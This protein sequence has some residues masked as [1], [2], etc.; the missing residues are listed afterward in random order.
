MTNIKRCFLTV[1]RL[2]QQLIKCINTLGYVVYKQINGGKIIEREAESHQMTYNFKPHVYH[3]KIY[4]YLDKKSNNYLL[5]CMIYREICL[6]LHALGKF[7]IEIDKMSDYRL[8]ND[9]MI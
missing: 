8:E 5:P 4:I 1:K 7:E 2:L 6:I 9:Q 3:H